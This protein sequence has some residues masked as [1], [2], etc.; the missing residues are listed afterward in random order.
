MPN[1]NTRYTACWKW[2]N[3]NNIKQYQRID[4]PL[5]FYFIPFC[6]FLMFFP[7][8][9]WVV[10]FR[11]LSSGT[12]CPFICLCRGDLFLSVFLSYYLRQN[13]QSYPMSDAVVDN[14]STG[15]PIVWGQGWTAI[16]LCSG[17]NTVEYRCGYTKYFRWSILHILSIAYFGGG[18]Y[19]LY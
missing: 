19:C 6:T 8:L 4:V 15:I 1:G 5:R 18:W 16:R 12:Q 2:V 7:F 3:K 11:F 13:W 9:N 10:S 17:Q 14:Y